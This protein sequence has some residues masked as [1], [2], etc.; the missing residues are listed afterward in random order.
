MT[1]SKYEKTFYCVERAERSACNVDKVVDILR[2]AG[3][4]MTCK[5][6][7]ITLWGEDEY[8]KSRMKNSH[9]SELGVILTKLFKA[10][11]IQRFEMDGEPFEVEDYEYREN[12]DVPYHINVWDEKGNG[13]RMVNPEWKPGN[14]RVK[15]MRTIVPKVRVYIWDSTKE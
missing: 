6:V 11:Y 1:I 13:Y 14:N 3:R 8:T 2:N 12:P 5:E 7:G 4:A 9:N 10:G 15:I